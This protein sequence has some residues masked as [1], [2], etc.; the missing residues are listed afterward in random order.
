[1]FTAYRDAK[2]WL[3][4]NA[5]AGLAPITPELFGASCTRFIDGIFVTIELVSLASVIGFALAIAVVLARVSGNWA[6]SIPAYIYCYVFRGTPLLVQLWILYFGIGALGADGLGPL[7][8]FFRDAWWVGLLALILNTT[9]YVAEIL[10]GGIENLPKG[11]IEAAEA[12]GLS[13]TT[14]MRRIVFPQALQIAWPAY[15]NEVI[16]LLKASALVSTIT[17]LDLMGQI[18]TVFSRSYSLEI[19]LYGAIMYLM[20]TGLLTLLLR[21]IEARLSNRRGGAKAQS[22]PT[23]S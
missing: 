11:Q 23:Q 17:V 10:R 16:L 21:A 9:A 7:W 14:R 13:W 3:S 2:I 5:C 6:L 8:P 4:D 19:F 22:S 15:G 18:R 1:M 12:Y 20:L